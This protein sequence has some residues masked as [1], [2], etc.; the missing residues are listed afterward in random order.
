MIN[1]SEIVHREPTLENELSR[2]DSKG[3]SILENL[4]CDAAAARPGPVCGVEVAESK[5]VTSPLDTGVLA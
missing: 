4:F 1:D 2:A 5:D 3:I